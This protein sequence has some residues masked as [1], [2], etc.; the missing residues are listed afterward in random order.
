MNAV[1]NRVHQWSCENSLEINPAKSQAMIVSPQK[2]PNLSP[3]EIGGEIIPYCDSARS[4]GLLIDCQLSWENHISKMCGEIY[5]GLSMLYQS[6]S[7]TPLSTRMRLVK[8]LLIPKILYCSNIYMGCSRESWDKII[9]T[10]NACARYVFNLKRSQSVSSWAMKILEC[11]IEHFV[12]FRSCLFL[13]NILRTKCPDYLYCKLIFP[14]R[15]RTGNLRFPEHRT[16]QYSQSFFI[17]GVHLW[18]SLSSKLRL[19]DSPSEF[20]RECL[21]YF[22]LERAQT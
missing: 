4:L 15:P 8:T 14:T 1:L 3:I 19:T 13:F 22:A 20:R 9:L 16:K 5:G 21:T 12:H 10:F 2:I 18:N 6:K 17:K 11:P 7:V